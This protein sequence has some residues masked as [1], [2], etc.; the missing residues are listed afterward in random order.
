MSKLESY[1]KL[2]CGYAA[3][4]AWILDSRIAC[5]TEKNDLIVRPLYS[6]YIQKEEHHHVV[7]PRHCKP[8]EDLR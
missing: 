2:V 4:L 6:K 7:V 1:N 8:Y 5:K 3:G